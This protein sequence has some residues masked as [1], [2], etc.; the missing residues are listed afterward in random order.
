[1]LTASK[2]A[3]VLITRLIPLGD[4]SKMIEK[5][6][7][8]A[9]AHRATQIGGN[10]VLEVILEEKYYVRFADGL[11]GGPGS[12][13]TDPSADVEEE[14]RILLEGNEREWRDYAVR[15]AGG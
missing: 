8:K 2:A 1:V 15:V 11:Q 9:R 7:G 13:P 12:G 14:R 6:E 5:F 4:R 3:G 10:H